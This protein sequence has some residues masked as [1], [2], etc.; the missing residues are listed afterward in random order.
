MFSL[1]Q[2]R[3]N[4]RKGPDGHRKKGT[5]KICY[6][7]LLEKKTNCASRVCNEMV[8]KSGEFKVHLVFGM[9]FK[10]FQQ[11]PKFQSF[12]LLQPRKC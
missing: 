6:I 5:C 11:T 10:I 2:I 4:R 1:H 3:G 8:R 7:K 9:R 12:N